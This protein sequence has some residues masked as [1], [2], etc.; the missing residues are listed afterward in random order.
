MYLGVVGGL[1]WEGAEGW[2]KPRVAD[3]RKR[4]RRGYTAKTQKTSSSVKCFSSF[5]VQALQGDYRHRHELILVGGLG[6]WSWQPRSLL[7]VTF[8]D[9]VPP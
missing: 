9:P 7:E 5:H 4:L 3:T 1:Y 8:I 2:G 6:V